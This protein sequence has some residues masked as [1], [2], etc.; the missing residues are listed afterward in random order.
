VNTP[1]RYPALFLSH[2]PANLPIHE[3]PARAFMARLGQRIGRP[4]AIIAMSDRWNTRGARFTGAMEPMTLHDHK[5]FEPVVSTLSWAAPGAPR[6]ALTVARSLEL[7]GFSAGLDPDRGRDS[8]V[9]AP[10]MLIDPAASIPTIQMSV[11]T[12]LDLREL[13]RLG[14]ALAPMRREGMLILCTGQAC[15]NPDLM[16]RAP[17]APPAPHVRPFCNWIDQRLAG[18]DAETLIE[19]E[20]AA[21]DAALA[22][23]DPRVLRP[24]FVAL[25]AGEGRRAMRVHEGTLH[26]TLGMDAWAFD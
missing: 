14:R 18:R 4:L 13:V 21:P 25:G 23:P 8:G 12:E 2:G 9:W 6:V 7:A 15:A 16:A 24:L 20:T 19:W 5:G 3:S 22:C 11:P 1:T 10:M 17:D 26:A